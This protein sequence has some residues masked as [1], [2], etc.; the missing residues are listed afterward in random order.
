MKRLLYYIAGLLA[1]SSCALT[2]S[3]SPILKEGTD[4][5]RIN[6]S[7]E[8]A[9]AYVTRASDQGF[10]NGDE[11]GIYVVDYDGATPGELTLNGTR[12]SNLRY[13]FDEASW[14]WIP[15]H[16]IYYK[17]KDTH[18]DVYGYYPYSSPASIEE[19]EFEVRKDQA[20]EGGEGKMGGYEASDFLWGKAA[21]VAP[22]DRTINVSFRHMMAAAKVTL[23]QGTGFDSAE[24][25]SLEKSVI[26]ES[27]IRTSKINLKTGE[28]AVTGTRPVTG[29]IAYR[30]GTDWRCIIVPQT[31]TAGDALF[32]LNVGGLP[33]ALRKGD[34][35][36]FVAGKQ[37]NFTITVNKRTETGT[38]EFV[39]TGESITPWENDPIS[40]DAV[41]REY[42]I[43]NVA[44]A[45]TLEQQIVASGKTID[46]VRNLK[47][48][49]KI[50][51]LDFIVMRDKMSSLQSLNLKEARIVEGNTTGLEN[52]SGPW[53]YS[54]PDVFPERA[55][56]DKT[57]LLHLVLPDVLTRIDAYALSGCLNITGSL[58]I[59]EGVTEIRDGAFNMV[60]G[61]TGSLYL[62]ST[63][64][65]IGNGGVFN[66]AGFMCEL[67]FPES[68]TEIGESAFK[69]CRGLY[70][71]LRLPSHLTSLGEHAFRECGFTGNLVIPQT[72][73]E[74]SNWAF[75]DTHFGGTLTLHDGITAIG[76]G[77]FASNGFKGELYLPKSLVVLS[78]DCFNGCDFSGTL[79]I[80]DDVATISRGCFAYNWRL[81][82]TI[83]IPKS[84]Q[85]I[86]ER[87]F[88]Q[89]SSLEGII[90]EDGVEA[91][92]TRA[93]YMCTGLGS[94]VC[95][96]S[97]PPYLQNGAFD[98]VAKD[99]FTLEVPE[100]AIATY[101]TEP[102]WSDFKRIAA[103]RNLVIRPS[104]ATAINTSVTRD[105][106]LNADEEWEVESQPDWVTLDKAYGEGKTEIKLTFAQM[107]QGSEAREGE[108]V[109]KLKT[110]DYR[111][112][113][114]VTQYNYQ[115]GEDEIVTLQS[116]TK[117]D[118]NNII[119]LGDGFDAKDISEGKLL[120]AAQQAYGYFFDIEPYK[121]Y[122]EYFNVY[123]AIPVS[124]ESGIGNVN[125]IVYT[126]F[127]TKAAG[128]G[129][130]NGA[131]DWNDIMKYACKAPTITEENL[132]STLVI[133][134]PNTTE[135]AGTCFMFDDGFAVAY[136]PMSDYGYPMDFRGVVQHEAGGHGFGKLLDEY[137]YH[138]EFIDG[139]TCSCCAHDFEL[140]MAKSM[141]YGRNLSLTGKMSE[142]DWAHLI[143]HP[144]YSGIVDVF[145]GGYFHTRSVYR[146]E[147]NSCMNN[148]IPYYSTIS[149]QAMVERIKAI[150]G[151]EFN[152]E[153]FIAK[154]VIVTAST[155]SHMPT[156]SFDSATQFVPMSQVHSH[157]E[158][159]GKCPAIKW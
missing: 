96:S 19:Y 119:I 122:K 148:D 153:D 149:R 101:S 46:K 44:E 61:M 36:T 66:R 70:G 142:V 41:A 73:T 59:P 6:I 10:A 47:V 135:Y 24:W 68:L 138:N 25:A 95:K 67:K 17:D 35:F 104:I 107:A 75:L 136:C 99:N 39:L 85:S 21:D 134:I 128:G 71:E 23:V 74:I 109:F 69:E 18:I 90:L 80:P 106:V 34:D 50:N 40:H 91:I 150:A 111:T 37:H 14:K 93:F 76:I 110:K 158:F 103:Y 33:Y 79:V 15:D 125:R 102:G 60:S 38:Y 118:N 112:R 3:E 157:P 123:T 53:M 143:F 1:V 137:I 141:G 16:E 145:E 63:L 133:M 72:L 86:G 55:L 139:C 116:S 5:S 9:Q 32:S 52:Y 13:T 121:T 144:K 92:G 140:A 113:C 4:A 51:C 155:M 124:P 82:G 30:S 83:T 120:A 100:T 64:K 58:I 156:K 26:T 115:Y 7:G 42:V 97:V 57:S 27:A 131:S 45:G 88:E 49:G 2:E 28:V 48:T 147:Q 29:T 146:S 31:I 84:V 89:C 129:V 159:M 22:S 12:A 152:L 105:L 130:N 62:P 54:E 151:E 8:I 78:E 87:A 65:K 132:S 98:G 127:N 43:V 20:D 81:M 117:G 94:I 108:V 154:D 56:S 126:K 77:A 114:K 11:I